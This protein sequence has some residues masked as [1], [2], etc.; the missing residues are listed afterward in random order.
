VARKRLAGTFDSG[1]ADLLRH[2]QDLAAGHLEVLAG[3]IGEPNLGLDEATWRRLAETVDLIVHPAALVNHV[4]PY[5]QLFAP[6]VGG[7]AELIRLASS[8]RLKPVNYLSTVAVIPAQDSGADEDADIRV[9]IP[10]RRL[11]QSYANGYATS[12]WAGEVLLREAHDLCGLPVATFRSDLI[13]AHTRYTGQLNVPDMFTRLLF[14]LITTGIAPRSFYRTDTAGNRRRAHFDGLPVDFTAEAIATLGEQATEGYRSYNVVNPHDDGISLD[15]V[16]DWLNDAGRTIR[17]IDDY[18]EWFTRFEIA[19]RELPEKQKQ[20]SLLPLLPAFARPSDAVRGSGI[21]ADRFR[22]A[23][24]AA[25]VGA[26]KD[27]PHVSASL[28]RKYVSD[29]HELKLVA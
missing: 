2:V 9:S 17:R 27:I 14:S 11:D 13:L 19:L 4:L 12:K 28:I 15:V 26:S 25:K 16:V 1:D 3:D 7:T 5:E 29:L 24:Q 23:V 18:E 6:N 22:A 8:T 21:P 10:V 20:H